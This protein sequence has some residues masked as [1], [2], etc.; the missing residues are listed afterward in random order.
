M[1]AEGHTSGRTRRPSAVLSWENRGQTLVTEEQFRRDLEKNIADLDDLGVP[2]ERIKYFVPPYE[3]Q[4]ADRQ[5]GGRHGPDLGQ[6]HA[7]HPLQCR[8]L[9]GGSPPFHPFPAILTGILDYEVRDQ[10]GLNGFL[11][12]LHL[13]VGPSGRTKCIGCSEAARQSRGTG[14]RIHPSGRP[15]QRR[16]GPKDA[17]RAQVG[18]ASRPAAKTN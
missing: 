11:L 14:L 16:A 15:A 7:R 2:R 5:V 3:G 13:G 8:L 9:A 18:Y 6:L 10:D 17:Y 4:R 1:V 12:L